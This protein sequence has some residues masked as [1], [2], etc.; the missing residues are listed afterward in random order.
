MDTRRLIVALVAAMAVFMGW[1]LLV[2][3]FA[4]PPPPTSQPAPGATVPGLPPALQ[5]PGVAP[6][7]TTASAPPTTGTSFAFTAGVSAEPVTLGGGADDALKLVLTPRGGALSTI[8]LV[9]R[10]TRKNRYTHRAEARSNDPYEL[11]A[12]VESAAGPRGSYV[13]HQIW[14]TE[15][16]HEARRLDGLLWEVVPDETTSHKATFQTTLRATDGAAELLRLTKTYELRPDQPVFEVGLRVENLSPQPLTVTLEQDGPIGICKEHLQ[17][18]M[19]RL[20]TA[21]RGADKMELGGQVQR[22]NLAKATRSGEYQP[23]ASASDEAP[24]AWTALSNKFFAVFTRPLPTAGAQ[25][26]YIAA[27]KGLVV[28]PQ[29]DDNPGDLLAR[30]ISTPLTLAPGTAVQTRYEV[31]AGAKDPD[32]LGKVSPAYVDETQLGYGLAQSAD[33]RCCTFQPLPQLMVGLLHGIHYVVRNYGLAIIVLVLIIRT[34][35]HPLTVFQQKSMYRMQDAMARVKPKLDALKEKYAND[36]VHLNQETMKL[37]A[38]ENVN[39]AASM[40]SMIPLFIQ[41]PILVALWTGLNTDIQLRHA[42]FDGWWIDDLSAPDA[43]ITFAGDGLTIP[44]LAWIPLVGRMFQHISSLNLLPILMGVSMWLQQKY[45]PK[46]GQQAKQ[47][48]TQKRHEE[49]RRSKKGGKGLTPAEQ[50][51]QQ[52]MI[53]YMMSILFQLM[54]YYMPAG[55]NLYWMSTNVFGIGESLII[56]KQ[57]KEE[58]ERAA[59]EGPK[60]GRTKKPGLISRLLKH[61]AEQA[62]QVQKRADNLTEHGPTRG[63]RKKKD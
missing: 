8:L 41:M 12:P 11:L 43:L 48:A 27:V 23:L 53:A 40:F 59:R 26:D 1:Q 3:R 34:L 30:L 37:W 5:Q 4:P 6:P 2:A 24:F 15:R 32:A 33:I 47:E 29:R 17:Y 55:L 19:R 44:I 22:A 28:D 13:T 35:L 54:F 50:L 38:E 45:M 39:P 57:L 7:V 42:P 14:I 46:P 16:N 9:A 20:L 63:P 18:D 60:S 51:R 31:Y 49:E 58:K 62:E 56:R 61:V 21:R 25:V 52:R 36:K 10:D